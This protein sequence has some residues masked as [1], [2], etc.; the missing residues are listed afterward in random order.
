M[1]FFGVPTPGQTAEPMEVTIPHPNRP[2]A[3]SFCRLSINLVC[4]YV[5]FNCFFFD[6]AEFSTSLSR[7]WT[8]TFLC[9]ARSIKNRQSWETS[10][11]AV[12]RLMVTYGFPVR[13]TLSVWFYFNKDRTLLFN[14]TTLLR[15]YLQILC[16]RRSFYYNYFKVLIKNWNLTKKAM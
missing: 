1:K 6:K 16:I 13:F 4:L 8:G 5:A 2:S 3:A 9:P 15:P 11:T 12:G 14:N 10:P 7:I